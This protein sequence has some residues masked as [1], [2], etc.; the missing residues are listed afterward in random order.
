ML[1]AGAESDSGLSGSGEGPQDDPDCAG[2][3]LGSV[4]AGVGYQLDPD[5]G[6]DDRFRATPTDPT[7]LDDLRAIQPEELTDPWER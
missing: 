7:V 6:T 3:E 4:R 1:Q 2:T 5:P